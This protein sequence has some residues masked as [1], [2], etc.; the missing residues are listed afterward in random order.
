MKKAVTL[1]AVLLVG[2]ALSLS[3]AQLAVSNQTQDNVAATTPM[4]NTVGVGLLLG[5]FAGLQIYRG[6]RNKLSR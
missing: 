1:A 3:Q 2:C 5:L 6:R 4:A